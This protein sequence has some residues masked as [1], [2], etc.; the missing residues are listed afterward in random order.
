MKF[1]LL[2]LLGLIN[3]SCTSSRP[4][5]Y[6]KPDEWVDMHSMMKRNVYHV[7]NCEMTVNGL[8]TSVPGMGSKKHISVGLFCDF[9]NVSSNEIE[10]AKSRF[11]LISGN[12]QFEN[13]SNEKTVDSTLSINPGATIKQSSLVYNGKNGI[14]Y[15]EYQSF[16]KSDTISLFFDDV[17]LS[18]FVL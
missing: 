16:L 3:L 7:E 18:R 14:S 2:L 15:D 9:K 11:K 8:F 13:V 12:Y 1:L 6:K 10:I 4:Q 17:L 5:L